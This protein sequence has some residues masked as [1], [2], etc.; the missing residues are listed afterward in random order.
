M[1]EATTTDTGR[2]EPELQRVMGKKLLLLFI[3]SATFSARR[4]RPHG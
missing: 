3:I 4:L 2:R 1:A